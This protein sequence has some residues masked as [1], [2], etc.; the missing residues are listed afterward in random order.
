MKFSN[1]NYKSATCCHF[2][3]VQSIKSSTD[4]NNHRVRYVSYCPPTYRT[5]EKY[6]FATH[7]EIFLLSGKLFVISEQWLL[8][9]EKNLQQHDAH[10]KLFPI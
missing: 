7:R 10:Q 4:K 5:L 8:Q 1:C 3:V 9:W 2:Q 6:N